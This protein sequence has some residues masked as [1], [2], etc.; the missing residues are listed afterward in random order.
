MHR[1]WITTEE[2]RMTMTKKAQRTASVTLRRLANRLMME[3]KITAT[4][5]AYLAK[6]AEALL[7]R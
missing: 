6:V 4:E 2:D 5:H 1:M 3:S 7:T